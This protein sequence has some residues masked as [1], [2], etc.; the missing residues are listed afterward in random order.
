MGRGRLV[1]LVAFLLACSIAC[2]GLGYW[3]WTRHVH[4]A[5]QVALVN[6]NLGADP[7]PAAEL[8]GPDLTAPVDP[9]DVWRPV[10]LTGEWLA[11]SGVQLRNRPVDGS[12]ASHSLG[13]LRT[14]AGTVLVVD[15]GWWAQTDTVP[16]GALDLAPGEVELTA[17]LRAAEPADPRTGPPGQVFSVTPSAVLDTLV[18]DG[19]LTRAEADDVAGD[20]AAGTYVMQLAPEP[21]AP[22]HAFPHPDTSLRSHLSY[23]FQWWF[24]ALAIPVAGVVLARRGREDDHGG[25]ARPQR[26]RRRPTLAEEEDALL[27]AQ[28]VAPDARGARAQDSRAQA[29]ETSSA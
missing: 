5:E 4:R 20:L 11:D 14:D 23:A 7:V 3:Q 26:V 2:V 12:N 10:G 27:D 17:R 15:R 19:R 16:G 9:D 8:L 1:G 24:F 21:T 28:A 29:S 22:L 25:A 18:A 13:L 6:A